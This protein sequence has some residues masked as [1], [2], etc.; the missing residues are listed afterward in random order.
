MLAMNMNMRAIIVRN[1]MGTVKTYA[2][3]DDRKS[4]LIKTGKAE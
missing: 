4:E 3:K 2:E 1:K